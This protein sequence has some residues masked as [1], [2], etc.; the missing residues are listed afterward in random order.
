MTTFWCDDDKDSQTGGVLSDASGNL[1]DCEDVAKS[2][3]PK[4]KGRGRKR[5]KDPGRDTSGSLS[6]VREPPDNIEDQGLGDSA[7]GQGG[8]LGE[9]S[10]KLKLDE[11]IQGLGVDPVGADFPTKLDSSM[12][13][14]KGEISSQAEELSSEVAE[15]VLPQ[16]SPLI[17]EDSGEN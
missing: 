6:P 3:T 17:R 10:K 7:F 4:K 9:G 8:D 14:D 13:T 5:F 15:N 2:S 1:S 12:D 11:D 16:G